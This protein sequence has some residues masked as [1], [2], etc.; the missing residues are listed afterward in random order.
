MS[1]HEHLWKKGFIKPNSTPVPN[2][3]KTQ[4]RRVKALPPPL[5]QKETLQLKR[6]AD[7]ISQLGY[8]SHNIPITAQNPTTVANPSSSK[9]GEVANQPT[10]PAADA[11]DIQTDALDEQD[12]EE[13]KEREEISLAAASDDS[14]SDDTRERQEISDSEAEGIAE[15][16]VNS[17]ENPEEDT[18]IQ[19]K[20]QQ[21][22]RNFLE[23]PINAPGTSPSSIQRQVNFRGLGNSIQQQSVET[24]EKIEP[25]A[26]EELQESDETIQRQ[27]IPNAE[28]DKISST[29]PPTIQRQSDTPAQETE[30]S[31]DNHNFLEIPVNVPDT[32]SSSIPRQVNLG[33]FTNSYSQ[34]IK[35]ASHP[36]LNQLNAFKTGEFVQ[37]QRIQS[38]VKPVNPILNQRQTQTNTETVQK[39]G[40]LPQSSD[41]S[42]VEAAPN[43][44]QDIEQQ[45]GSGQPISNKIRQ[46]MEQAFGADFSQVQVHTDSKSNKLNQSIQAKAFTTG[47]DIFFKQGE[48]Q[49]D[50]QPGQELL[51]H[52]LTHVVQQNG[53]KLQAKT[54]S[55]VGTKGNKLQT[56]ERLVSGFPAQ[57][58]IQ[59][60]ENLQEQTV[61][62]NKPQPVQPTP[63]P[64]PASGG[65]A[66]PA[67]PLVNE[68]GGAAAAPEMV[69]SGGAAAAPEMAA[70][71]STAATQAGTQPAASG[72]AAPGAG[73]GATSP[74]SPEADPGF[75]A[76][77][78]QVE[79][80]AE[81]ERQHDPAESESQ[82]AQD[83][84]QS[85]DNEVESQAQDAQVQQM[86]QQE[87]GT[88][89]AEAFKA[90]LL[91][92]IAA[93]TPTNQEEAEQFQNNNQ[94]DSV[95]Q[96][97]SSQVTQEQEQAAGGIQE[98]VEAEPDTSSIDARE[99]TPLE[100][101]EAGEPTDVDAEGAVPQPRSEAEVSAPLQANSQ[102]LDQQMAAEN[103]TEEQLANS[104]EPEFIAALDAK[105][106]AQDHAATAPTAYRA[107]EQGILTQGQTEAQTMAQTQLGEMHGQRDQQLN[108]VMGLQS[109][110]QS[111]DE[112]E[113]TRVANEINGIYE[114]TKTDVET[115]LS[116]LDTEVTNKFDA[117][118][119][120][121]KQK[122]EAYVGEKV[123]AYKQ[124]RYGEWWDVTGW[125]ERASDA[126][127]GLPPE[128]NQFFVDGRQL[129]IDEMDIALTDIANY[130]AEKL[131][132]AKERINQGKQD[133]QDYVA[134][135]PDNLRQVGEDAAQNIQSQFDQLEE[136]VNNKQNELIDSLAQQ[137]STSLQEVDARIEEMQ[138]EN[139]GLVSQFT[140]M[141]GG[142][143]NTMGQIRS[144]L[145]GVL[146]G[147][148]GA[149]GAILSDPIG[150]LG[151]L[152]S[153]VK[154]GLDKFVGNIATHLQG[155]LVAW[156]TGTMGGLGIQIPDDLFSLEGIFNLVAQI[157]GLT[158]DYIRSKA[159]RMFGDP[160]VAAM[161]QG[162]E[163]F[164]VFQ[165]QGAIA[166][167]EQVQ[168]QF[169]DLKEQV[170]DQI[171]DMV[172]TQVIQS[173]V[174]WM[175]GLLTPAGAFVKAA[176]TIYNIVMFFVNRGSQVVELVQAI[177]ESIGAIASGSLGQA[178]SLIESALAKALP[179][180]I[181]FL[182]SLIG[183]SG[184][185][186]KVQDVVEGIR[187]R[188][189]DAIEFVL[190][191]A[192]QMAASLLR[193][194]GIGRGE[195]DQQN[196]EQQ[197]D[198]QPGDGE[199]GKTINFRAAD[200]SH[201]L[202]INT[203]GTSTTVMV[204]STPTPVEAK[205]NE[206][207][208]KLDSVP[209]DKRPQ[210]Q[211]LLGTARQHLGTTEQKAQN[212]AKEME[213][214]KQNSADEAAINEAEQADNQTE[215][216]QE[217]LA[218]VLKQLCDLF[219]DT[220]DG[221]NL[222]E[223]FSSQLQAAAPQAKAGLQA[224]LEQLQETGG[225]YADWNAVKNTLIT[226]GASNKAGK[227]LQSPLNLDH[228][229]GTYGHNNMAVPA[230][231]LAVEEVENQ[232][233][234]VP[235]KAKNNPGGYVSDH[236]GSLHNHQGSFPESK[237]RLQEHIFDAGRRNQAEDILIDEFLDNLL[238]DKESTHNL[239]EPK[240][241]TRYDVGDDGSTAIEYDTHGGAHFRVE[242][243][244]NA[245]VKSVQGTSLKL[246]ADAGVTGRGYT[247]R[248]PGYERNE[249][250]NASHL[251][252]DQFLGSGYKNSAN[253]ITTS[254]HYN[255]VVMKRA[256]DQIIRFVQRN[257]A[258]EFNME[259]NVTWGELNSPE[260]IEEI[261]QELPEEGKDEVRNE[262][263]AFVNRV[264]P[265]FK[266]C[267]NVNYYVTVTNEQTGKEVAF[268]R[269]IGPDAWLGLARR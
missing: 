223:R 68:G 29:E 18:E 115:I 60:K 97:V 55:Q 65:N 222:V 267:M 120:T 203:Q 109:D 9:S 6:Q 250:L 123:D 98:T 112:Q 25:E 4:R 46:P 140:D 93:I 20:A 225:N 44:E 129:Y 211:S 135:L 259:V 78:S 237:A 10:T 258:V 187:K 175:L 234:P 189:D 125:D 229:Y 202:W 80:V 139:R 145:E 184:L 69:E 59:R 181:G 167:W 141:M 263:Q 160:V 26:E 201:R 266:R 131:N 63:A 124:E 86:E 83:A 220:L 153:G 5:S 47:T 107:E 142:V 214:A 172:I 163:M 89:N 193:R 151:N 104:N 144:M 45:R 171:K 17:V 132:E 99:A 34:Q 221:V 236:K 245:M 213:E 219:G 186:R 194:L 76:V 161:E 228:D 177:S 128:V 168:D 71:G 192:K 53:S 108:E 185:A 39:K 113:R 42:E 264:Q 243:D 13:T 156:L 198:G 111:R 2:P 148:A 11:V 147:A 261:L 247:G 43:I 196:A 143:F 226:S 134:G 30:K 74:A 50:N 191:K 180:A 70:G 24:E 19:A 133:I 28:E 190:N 257:K 48:Y 268:D 197:G 79:G 246:K 239:Y 169:T 101:P 205:L 1:S 162:L 7:Q 41:T 173:G 14:A 12:Q 110:T 252:A 215:A 119:A 81:Q 178:A 165:S 164:Q 127:F 106:Q 114:Q 73:G 117:G 85:P 158:W 75:Q 207:Q 204:A 22:T 100:Q 235:E 94:I 138:A 27:E 96:E 241:L 91:E 216:A 208:G 262:V 36:R 249:D 248:S 188:I 256:E 206:W 116:D 210:A 244:P 118:A 105:R 31:K 255:Q 150:F 227:M 238:S 195:E 3:F 102:E 230:L 87:P 233:K 103:V 253:L 8:N 174:S 200:E 199:V 136:S 64:A 149:I 260:V 35:P 77:V 231:G 218:D 58:K 232:G 61:K 32:P 92:R 72:G 90:A 183:V 23:L 217:T 176:Q 82:E 212:T 209:E 157:L 154:Q 51:A 49:P 126:V 57:L 182:A 240:N 16:Q 265:S 137:Y 269:D 66:A 122:F 170:I 251:I 179:V 146:A 121:A 33:K 155:G 21:P 254:A 95:R 159:V 54:D 40:T 15:P 37:P 166:L 242:L 88:F 56:K 62:E 67:T 52:E 84:A 38:P 130:V 224:G 152:I